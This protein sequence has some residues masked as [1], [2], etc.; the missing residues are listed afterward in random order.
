MKTLKDFT[1]EQ[2]DVQRT[3]AQ[4]YLDVEANG[5]EEEANFVFGLVLEEFKKMNNTSREA[6]TLLHLQIIRILKGF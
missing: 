6:R 3:L 1:K 2:L 4:M 5:T